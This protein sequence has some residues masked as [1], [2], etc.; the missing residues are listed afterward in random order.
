MLRIER[1]YSLLGHNTFGIDARTAAFVEYGS[2]N[3]LLEAAEMLRAS[4]LPSPWLHI[5]GGRP[6]LFSP[7][8]PGGVAASPFHWVGPLPVG[9]GGGGGGG[10]RGMSTGGRPPGG[11]GGKPAAKA[12]TQP[13]NPPE[14]VRVESGKSRVHKDLPSAENSPESRGSFE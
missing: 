8:L 6:T 4:R 3:E 5:G 11:G 1:D 14:K 12:P 9:G 10:G 13:K 2:E 7:D